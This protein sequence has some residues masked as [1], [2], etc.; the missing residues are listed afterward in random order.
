[1]SV[2]GIYINIKGNM[3]DHV[4]YLDC[5]D[6]TFLVVICHSS[7]VSQYHRGNVGEGDLGSL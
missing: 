3:R 5:S 4:L 2:K 7:S 6:V 1:M